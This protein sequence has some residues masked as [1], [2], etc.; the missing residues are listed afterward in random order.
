MDP[1]PITRPVT[2]IGDQRN[3]PGPFAR[4]LARRQAGLEEEEVHE[5]EAHTLPSEAVR[6]DPAMPLLEALDRLRVTNVVRPADLE[7]VRTLR[8][9]KAYQDP[10]TSWYVRGTGSE[11]AK[12]RG[13][14][15]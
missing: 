8:A 4:R 1:S 3:G 11:G 9:L 13:S 10:T 14:E 7:Y 15:G 2:P 6:L 5:F 12:E